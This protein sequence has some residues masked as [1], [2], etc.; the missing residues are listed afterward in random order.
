MATFIHKCRLQ[1]PE[2]LLGL[3]VFQRKPHYKK[4]VVSRQRKR[5][6]LDARTRLDRV[7]DWLLP[8]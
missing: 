8:V 5:I 6:G 4:R 1:I 2:V 7:G 3:G